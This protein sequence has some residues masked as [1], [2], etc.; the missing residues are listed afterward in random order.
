[1]AKRHLKKGL[2]H[3]N[4]KNKKEGFT[5]AVLGLGG[6]ALLAATLST[7]ADAQTARQSTVP[8]AEA[9][10]ATQPECLAYDVKLTDA[11][12]GVTQGVE[13]QRTISVLRSL[14]NVEKAAFITSSQSY[15]A[16][17]QEIFKGIA[18]S[19]QVVVSALVK[20]VRSELLRNGLRN[21][22]DL[23]KLGEIGVG[24]TVDEV[25]GGSS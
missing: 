1:M 12:V 4:K 21:V 11:E 9:T 25:G 6:A 10:K 2:H 8:T 22:I 15:I 13:F 18:V 19:Q 3:G 20:M 17:H 23:G 7:R 16:S 14:G 5:Q 24:G